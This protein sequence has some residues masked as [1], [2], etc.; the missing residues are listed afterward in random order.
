MNGESLSDLT[1]TPALY[2][3]NNIQ[4]NFLTLQA[5]INFQGYVLLKKH[6]FCKV[7]YKAYLHRLTSSGCSIKIA[8]FT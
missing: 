4:N 3:L 2:T 1:C 7:M 8:L 5:I 6:L